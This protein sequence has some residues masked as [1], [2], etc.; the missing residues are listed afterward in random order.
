MVVW[1]NGEHAAQPLGERPGSNPVATG[2]DRYG[3]HWITL[4]QSRTVV[5]GKG[6]SSSCELA[7]MCHTVD[8][9]TAEEQ[10]CALLPWVRKP[11]NDHHSVI[12]AGPGKPSSHLPE[13]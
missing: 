4:T 12:T 13:T 7:K 10:A 11:H 6:K 2:F 3:V 9:E 1:R 5:L 8:H